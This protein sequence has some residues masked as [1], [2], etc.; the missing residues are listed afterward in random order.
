MALLPYMWD[1][2][3]LLFRPSKILDQ[4]F[5]LVLDPED[6]LQPVTVPSILTKSPAGYLRN[7]RP[8][9]ADLDAGSTVAFDK[10][11]F[12]ANLDVSQ[13]NPEEISVKVTG[14]NT[15]TVEGKHE[16]KEDEHGHIYRHFVRRYVVPKGCDVG[17]GGVEAVFGRGADADR[18]QGAAEGDQAEGGAREADGEAVQG[19]AVS[20]ETPRREE[21]KSATR[22]EKKCSVV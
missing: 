4:Q 7:W 16:E 18:A 12:Q 10:D 20:G 3:D 19:V 15:V 13:F 8:L 2:P 6:L 11:K 9:G 21:K 22:S 5:G 17:E 14:E 1:Y